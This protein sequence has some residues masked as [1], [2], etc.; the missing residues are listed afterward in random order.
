MVTAERNEMTLA[1]VLKS[2]ESPR[3]KDNL[4]STTVEVC[5]ICPSPLKPNPGLSGPP[6]ING[7]WPALQTAGA[8]T[9]RVPRPSRTLRRAGRTTAYTTSSVERTRVVRA[10]SPPTL[11]KNARMGHP[12]CGGAMQRWATRPLFGGG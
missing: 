8:A 7:G 3:H 1:T 10:A 5:D 11:A 2:R 12:P 6:A 4:V 9:A